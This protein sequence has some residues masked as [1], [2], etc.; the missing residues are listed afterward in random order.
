MAR[1]GTVADLLVSFE[2]SVW[3]WNVGAPLSK[4]VVSPLFWFGKLGNGKRKR[5]ARGR[6]GHIAA[7]AKVGE[8]VKQVV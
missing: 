6:Q 3:G 2:G 1:G 8:A 7:A 4:R 5:L